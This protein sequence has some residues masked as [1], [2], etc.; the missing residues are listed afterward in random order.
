MPNHDYGNVRLYECLDGA[1]RQ[2]NPIA[3]VNIEDNQLCFANK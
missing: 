3:Y 1:A 2:N